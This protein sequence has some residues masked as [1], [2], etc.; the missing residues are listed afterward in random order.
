MNLL[1]QA[2][3]LPAYFSIHSSGFLIIICAL[4]GPQF[5]LNKSRGS[6]SLKTAL[7]HVQLSLANKE[8][9]L[10]QSETGETAAGSTQTNTVQ[11]FYT[12]EQK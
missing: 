10:S 11:S 12:P 4:P 3:L 8:S 2:G 1:E 5:A 9:G 7:I 6:C